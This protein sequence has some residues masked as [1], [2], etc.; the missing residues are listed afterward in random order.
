V[1]V[2]LLPSTG[3]AKFVGESSRESWT[4]VRSAHAK[5]DWA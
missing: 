2:F 4:K 1:A 3:V 5:N